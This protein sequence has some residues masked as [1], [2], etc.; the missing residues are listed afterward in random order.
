MFSPHPPDTFVLQTN[1]PRPEDVECLSKLMT[2]VGNLLDHSD[3]VQRIQTAPGEERKARSRE[4]MN[5][6][7]P[8]RDPM[9][10]GAHGNGHG[11]HRSVEH[12]RQQE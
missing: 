5:V 3:R 12:S 1:N 11:V 6:R 7:D 4:L 10:L 8:E 9:G 2:T